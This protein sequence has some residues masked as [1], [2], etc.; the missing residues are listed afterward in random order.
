MSAS[1]NFLVFH[2]GQAER[3]RDGETC[4]YA[5][6]KIFLKPKKRFYI[7]CLL[8]KLLTCVVMVA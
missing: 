7:V 8:S 2:A 1:N 3:A 6:L 5:K 4:Y